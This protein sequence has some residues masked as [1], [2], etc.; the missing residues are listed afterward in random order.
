MPRAF[1][2]AEGDDARAL[3][4]LD[5]H[6][7][8]FAAAAETLY[9]VV[10]A[11]FPVSFRP[12]PG[13]VVRVTHEQLAATLRGAMCASSAYAPWAVPHVLESVD[14]SKPGLVVDD[15]LAALAACGSAFGRRAMAPHMRATWGALRRVLLNP[16][17][18]GEDLNAEG[19]AR[20]ATRMFAAEWATGGGGPGRV[21][22][23]DLA[24]E[25]SCLKDAA[26]ALSP[27]GASEDGEENEN[28]EK[29]GGGCCGGSGHDHDHDHDHDGGGGGCGNARPG[30]GAT[31]GAAASAS[32]V[33]KRGHALVAGAGRVLGAVAASGVAAA[34]AAIARGL[35]PLLDA[36][37]LGPTGDVERVKPGVAPLLLVLA[38]PTISGALDGSIFGGGEEETG[39]G[40]I[41]G[42]QG[43][44]GACGPRL[45]GLFA[46]AAAKTIKGAG[47]LTRDDGV[48]Y[49]EDEEEAFVD[50]SDGA[51]LG[52]AGL[53]ALT[54]FP[55]GH[56]LSSGDGAI[57]A[58]RALVDAATRPDD[59]PPAFA[60]S[61]ANDEETTAYLAYVG[62]DVRRRAGEA[63]GAA[64][65]STRDPDMAA[66]AITHALPPLMKL[67][68]ECA[69]GAAARALA[70]AA[71][72]AAVSSAAWKVATP[73]LCAF[74]TRPRDAA[75]FDAESWRALVDALA[76]TSDTASTTSTPGMLQ[77]AATDAE[78]ASPEEDAAAA[79]LATTFLSPRAPA[80]P[81]GPEDAS[82]SASASDD[83]V[84]R[85]VRAAVAACAVETQEPIVAA[86]IEIVLAARERREE[87]GAF[88]AAAAALSATRPTTRVP[89]CV[90]AV[91]ALVAVAVDDA[92]SEDDA[93]AA[94]HAASALMHKHGGAADSALGPYS[95]VGAA[96]AAGAFA[97]LRSPRGVRVVGGVLRALAARNDA[98]A[99]ALA[100][101]LA[102]SLASEDRELAAGAAKALGAA[103]SPS[104]GGPGVAKTFHGVEKPLF[105]QKL[106][107]TTLPS[108]LTPLRAGA[109]DLAHRPARL[110]ALVHLAAHA[111]TP[112]VLQRGDAV[113]PLLAEA[114]RALADRETPFA[115]K[116]AL[117]SAITLTASFLSDER[118]RDVLHAHADEH[119][120]GIIDALCALGTASA[121]GRARRRTKPDERFAA[122][123]PT[124]MSAVVRETALEALLAAVALPF[125]AVYPQRKAVMKAAT[126]A[127]DD[128]KRRVRMA[129]GRC[130]EVWRKLDPKCAY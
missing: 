64:A 102:S 43:V 121:A 111:P 60:S 112:A 77:R 39:T 33:T 18:G 90:D 55:T 93:T 56:G 113:V 124:I 118:A 122:G 71:R 6:R 28:A 95:G 47:A 9:D 45:A 91:R 130:R 50:A 68:E 72:V 127:L 16:P 99:P 129:A 10:A 100:A 35:T 83:G 63:L 87:D 22:L 21:S 30:G 116:D 114:M 65:A 53:R 69:G 3:S 27:S 108:I 76:G 105:R 85:L 62:D 49:V 97:A 125:S 25:D 1:C 88:K 58:M 8:A 109:A 89:S 110:S 86:A 46:A 34:S 80:A 26:A 73:I 7:A 74:A 119:G 84:V 103:L 38:M 70:A 15:A 4:K 61:A 14:G 5:A 98:T 13:D 66:A 12:P 106:F 19:V 52:I 36:A 94:S 104:G 123:D 31:E 17:Q 92:S 2:G 48:E 117:A 107:S 81:A 40:T 54:A 96:K 101:E 57:T 128:P 120:G 37:G 126:A 29:S 42:A 59:P 79:A 82:A 51:I 41:G 75:A 11:Y 32:E 20:W 78:G 24:L 23:V 115:D 67:C 44:L